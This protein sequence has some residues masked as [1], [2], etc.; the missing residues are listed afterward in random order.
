M[1][2]RILVS[3]VSQLLEKKKK[4]HPFIRPF[5]KKKIGS[6][7]PKTMY[8]PFIISLRYEPF[9]F[10]TSQNAQTWFFALK[11]LFQCIGLTWRLLRR[12]AQ[13]H[14]NTCRNCT[15]VMYS[16]CRH[17]MV[18][19]ASLLPSSSHSGLSRVRSAGLGRN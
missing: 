13:I 4:K 14:M 1:C 9:F 19:K 18:R 7:K 11:L 2:Y 10:N 12:D 17:D 16:E 6:E 5:K 15:C 8:V 3:P